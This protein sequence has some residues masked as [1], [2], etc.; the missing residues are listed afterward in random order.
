MPTVWLGVLAGAAV[1]L[2]LPAA[3][4]AHGITGRQDVPLP[5]WL[6]LWSA[7]V[8]LVV[9]FVALATLW[10]RPRLQA[11]S[12]R[13][14]E[15]RF[16]RAVASPVVGALCGTVGAGLFALVV[17]AGLRG[18]SNPAENIAPTFVYIT[19]WLGL[20]P[21]S[22]LLGDVFRALNPWRV[23]ARAVAWLASRAAGGPVEAPFAYPER[24]GRWPAV[25]GIV[26][27]GWL[28]L[29][30][31]GGDVPATIA[32]AALVYSVATWIG[33]ALYGIEEWC[34]RGEAFSVYF[35]LIAR[36]SPWERRGDRVG[37]Q[38]PLSG[39]AHWR[40]GPGAVTF[41]CALIGI[42]SF[43]GFSSGPTYN[44]WIPSLQEAV[45]GV[46]FGPVFALELVFGLSML[47][48]VALV[49]AFFSLGAWGVA[50][51]SGGG[52]VRDL[53]RLFAHTLAPIALAYTLAH[54]VSFFAF[55]GQDILRLA[56]DPLG[57]G[58]DIFGTAGREIDFTV[59]S[60]TFIWY[61]Q[62]AA[63]VAG[64]VCGLIL[65]HDRAV[66]LF[67]DPRRAARSQYVMLAVM[68]CFTTLALWLLS[69]Q[70]KL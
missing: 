66:A 58:V 51:V 37:V 8:V 45:E 69:E 2:A 39:L 9:S 25:V 7:A 48:T 50:R 49:V 27:F 52:S 44:G 68:V 36:I 53:A 20:L 41:V 54:Y 63:I 32:Q 60:T 65:A 22:L 18:S 17:V 38:R 4:E 15:G 31:N 40:P 19:F 1:A 3:A 10:P 34:D 13:P 14:L 24:L 62:V 55:Q 57:D 33:M 23:V 26:A 46:G 70:S 28:E 42:V 6:F 16:G 56:S 43:D 5:T 67:D 64:H 30:A 29:A 61:F 59:I 21:L 35:N 11:D 47:A 12:W